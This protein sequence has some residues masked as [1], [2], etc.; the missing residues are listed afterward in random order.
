[1][2]RIIGQVVTGN[3][4]SLLGASA[5]RGRVFG[6]EEETGLGGH[7]V[8][9]L[10][11]AGWAQVFRRDANVVGQ[12]IVLNGES[13]AVI[14]IAAERFKGHRPIA[15]PILWVPLTQIDALEHTTGQWEWRGNNRLDVLGRLAPGI[16]GEA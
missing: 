5:E 15:S 12:S 14:G 3:Y 6:A 1:P 7:R 4:F 16:T 9:V 11:H 13:Y 8:V 10:S 2:R